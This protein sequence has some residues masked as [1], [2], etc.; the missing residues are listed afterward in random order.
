MIASLQVYQDISI[1]D[2]F[3][4]SSALMTFLSRYLHCQAFEEGNDTGSWREQTKNAATHPVHTSIVLTQRSMITCMKTLLR[5]IYLLESQ[6]YRDKR[7]ERDISHLWIYSLDGLNDKCWAR[8]KPEP[9]V[10][11]RS[12]MWV[13]GPKHLG[14]HRLLVPGHQQEAGLEV[15]Q[16]GQELAPIWNANIEM[17]A[18]TIMPQCRFLHLLLETI[19]FISTL[20]PAPSWGPGTKALSTCLLNTDKPY[21]FIFSQFG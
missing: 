16:L 9:R 1:E 4:P 7:K 3:V 14:H 20:Y 8:L 6:I 2:D 5:F 13:A 17:V 11:F 10:S 18:L 15:E 12:L 21:C 19:C